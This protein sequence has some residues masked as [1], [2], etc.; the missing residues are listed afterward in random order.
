[1]LSV[2]GM[3]ALL[4]LI[5]DGIPAVATGLDSFLL[6]FPALKRWAKIVS[7]LRGGH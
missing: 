4:F 7:P 1:M 3:L 2:F 5:G 6:R